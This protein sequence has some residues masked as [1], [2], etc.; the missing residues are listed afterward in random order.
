MVL[1]LSCGQRDQERIKILFEFL[2][3]LLILFRFGLGD[4]LIRLIESFKDLE[5]NLTDFT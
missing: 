1:R 5:L 3:N 2:I 4:L